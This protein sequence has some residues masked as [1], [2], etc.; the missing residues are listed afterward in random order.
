MPHHQRPPWNDPLVKDALSYA[1][2]R[3]KF[4]QL[5]YLGEYGLP[6]GGLFVPGG[7]WE[8]PY[9]RVKQIPGYN[10]EDPEGNK[11][12][13]REL[14]AQA[15][16]KPGELRLTVTFWAT[17]QDNVPPIIED[18][19]AVGIDAKPLILET[20]AAYDAWTNGAFD[21]GVHSFW[22]ITADPD[23]MLYEHFYTGSDRNYNRYAKP[24]VDRL[25]DQMSTTVDPE[26]R[27][28]RAWDVAETIMRDQ[29]KILGGFVVY[30]P[31]TGPRVR[32]WAP[33]TGWLAL[34]GPSVR[35][36]HVWL[37]EK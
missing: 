25:I 18:F 24:E 34:S 36:H 4:A 28:K 17:I 19:Q 12:K 16:Y 31:L 6:T 23:E 21:V 2:D 27:K 29:G 32:G 3:K 14:L 22:Y 20:A 33:A 7:G 5:L 30:T 11:K 26:L 8:M 1:F 10:L 13:A 37:T 15:G 9:E 35:F